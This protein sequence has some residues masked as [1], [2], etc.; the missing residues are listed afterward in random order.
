MS[1]VIPPLPYSIQTTFAGRSRTSSAGVSLTSETASIS[2]FSSEFE[3]L[4]PD[5]DIEYSFQ[6]IVRSHPL[7][8]AVTSLFASSCTEEAEA[9]WKCKKSHF[10]HTEN[11]D[12][13]ISIN[14]FLRSNS[15]LRTTH[16]RDDDDDDT[17][18]NTEI[19]TPRAQSVY[20]KRQYPSKILTKAQKLPVTRVN[21]QDPLAR[22]LPLTDEEWWDDWQS[23]TDDSDYEQLS[24]ALSA[25]ILALHPEPERRSKTDR[26]PS[27]DPRHTAPKI[28]VAKTH[29]WP[30][31]SMSG[32]P[33][34]LVQS[35]G[36]FSAGTGESFR[37]SG[38][39]FW[40]T[41]LSC[42]C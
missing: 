32:G 19:K 4:S 5:K 41:V 39:S 14:E 11:D 35:Y 40:K 34:R 2:Q 18:L 8:S 28:V 33:N 25:S 38:R 7:P 36:T 6:T 17:I 16:G 20:H 21:L 22:F 27:K 26:I 1:G 30:V 24:P 31:V 42:F 12:S 9:T 23:E 15:D 10:Q 37:E 3:D 13:A 29:T